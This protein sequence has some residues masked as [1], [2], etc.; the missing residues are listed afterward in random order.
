MASNYCHGSHL[1]G[2]DPPAAPVPHPG[3][4]K[5]LQ[6]YPRILL[7]LPCLPPFVPSLRIVSD[8]ITCHVNERGVEHSEL[9]LAT[10]M[11][12]GMLGRNLGT[13]ARHVK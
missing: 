7:L 2:V 1:D 8:N 13:I 6:N 11:H 12:T 9:M 4:Q 5:S 3:P 10:S